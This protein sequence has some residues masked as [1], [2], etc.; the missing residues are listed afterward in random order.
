MILRSLKLAW[1][2]RPRLTAA[3]L[4]ACALTLFFAGQFAYT[5]VYWATHRD[6]PV[7]P[8]MTV[9]YV[10]NSWNVD[11]PKIDA[12]AGLPRPGV[13][14]HPQPLDEI[15]RDRGVPVEDIIADVEAAIAALRARDA[16]IRALRDATR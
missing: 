10:A 15:A 9:G 12:I 14:G 3:F 11:G 4:T 7:R 6:V 2:L 1:T 16:A 8:W 13:K 5:T